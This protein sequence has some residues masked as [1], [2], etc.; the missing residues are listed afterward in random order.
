MLPMFKVHHTT[1]A[2]RCHNNKIFCAWMVKS[3]FNVSQH[4]ETLRHSSNYLANLDV[5]NVNLEPPTRF[6]HVT[7]M[8]RDKHNS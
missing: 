6:T 1:Q 5:G 8:I 2:K 4:L 3:H 7:F